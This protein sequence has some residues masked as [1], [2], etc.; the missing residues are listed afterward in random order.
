[1][2]E[3]PEVE[4]IR[5]D[6][7]R[8]ASGAA[9]RAVHVAETPNALR[10]IRPH[11]TRRELQDPL[12][13]AAITG[14]GR[15]GK[16]LVL[17]LD[18]SGDDEYA[19]VV[20]LG[21]SGQLLVAPGDAPVARHT[22]VVMELDQGRQLRYVDPRTFGHLWL[23]RK[24]PDGSIDALAGLGP[25]ALG[26][27]LTPAQLGA[28]L[29]GHTTRLKSALMDQGVVAGIGNIYSDEIAFVAKVHPFRACD[30]LS[31]PAVGRLAGAIPEI[32]EQAIT[33]RGTS[34]EDAQYRD[35]YGAAGDHA[36]YLKV[37]QRTGQ[38]CLRCGGT[39]AHARFTNRYAH[40]CPSCQ[41]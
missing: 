22:H 26:A 32:L 37:Y 24:A 3:L 29:A 18:H 23:S 12:A 20:H 9:I 2:P 30:T 6:L 10:V 25:D 33:H 4:V 16:H 13:G 31:R 35:L 21:M 38:P 36:S 27:R 40:F 5:R 34:A 7:E 39:I 19:L 14:V 41:R 11:T 17:H 15:H 1:M 8:E 28:R